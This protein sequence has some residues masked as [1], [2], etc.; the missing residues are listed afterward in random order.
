MSIL[1]NLKQTGLDIQTDVVIKP[2]T[3]MKI[4]GKAEYFVVVQNKKEL[5]DIVTAA[6]KIKVPIT[7]LGGASNVLISD[8]GIKGLVIIN[9]AQGIRLTSHKP[10]KV[11]ADSGTLVNHLV[12]YCLENGYGN[13]EEF[14]GI[15]GT[16]GGAIYNNSHHLK[17]LIGSYVDSVEV[18]DLSGKTETLTQKQCQFAYDYSIFHHQPKIILSATFNLSIGDKKTLLNKSQKALKRRRDTQ[19]LEFPSSGCI[20][21]NISKKQIN[22]AIKTIDI[23]AAGYLIDQAGLKGICVNDACV[24]EKHANFIINKGNATAEDVVRL[25]DKIARLIKKEYGITLEKEVFFIGK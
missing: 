5:V 18:I 13:L 10:L 23:P 8:L 16:V 3:Y 22:R 7:I 15:P 14:L 12:N 20:F 4:G 6:I 21:K 2:Y 1:D 11:T 24:S 9:R 25:S 19:P 17:H